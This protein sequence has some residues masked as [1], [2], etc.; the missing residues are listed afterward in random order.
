MTK[1]RRTLLKVGLPAGGVTVLAFAISLVVVLTSAAAPVKHL[2]KVVPDFPRLHGWPLP[3][4]PHVATRLYSPFTGEPVR[5]LKPVLAV[6]ID[7]IVDARPSRSTTAWPE[8]V[9]TAYGGRDPYSRN[10]E[11][12]TS[13]Y[14]IT[15]V[16]PPSWPPSTAVEGLPS[17]HTSQRLSGADQR[18]VNDAAG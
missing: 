18:K 12:L 11:V 5:A 9:L 15:T 1:R 2:A 7:N 10:R 16:E 3:A 14:W 17:I 4:P 6:K 13:V 8:P